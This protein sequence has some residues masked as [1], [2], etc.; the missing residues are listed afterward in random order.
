MLSEIV[1][2]FDEDDIKKCYRVGRPNG[3]GKGR[4]LRVTFSNSELKS[5]VLRSARKLKASTSFRKVYVNPDR[6]PVQQAEHK[7]LR[8][9]LLSRRG[10]GE[11]VVIFKQSVVPRA[12]VNLKNFH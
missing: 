3:Q 6:T 11:D 10:K 5:E 9:E 2:D 7:N 1:D 8:S 12:D 4:L